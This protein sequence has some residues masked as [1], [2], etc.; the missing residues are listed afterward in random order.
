MVTEKEKIHGFAVYWYEKMHYESLAE[1]DCEIYLWDED[2][3]E[4]GFD[5]VANAGFREKYKDY[6][7]QKQISDEVIESEQDYR[8]L[9][10]LIYYWLRNAQ[11]EVP[12]FDRLDIFSRD[13]FIKML[14]QLGRL[15]GADPAQFTGIPK[16]IKIT[17]HDEG[18][19]VVRMFVTDYITQIDAEGNVQHSNVN[20]SENSCLY[21]TT[22]TEKIIIPQDAARQILERVSEVFRVAV[23]KDEREKYALWEIEIKNT[24]G[25]CYRYASNRYDIS[26]EDRTDIS[27]IIR[28]TIGM[29][30]IYLFDMRSESDYI[31]GIDLEYRSV[32]CTER[33]WEIHET[34]PPDYE[35][36]EK[37]IINRDRGTLEY[38][39]ISHTDHRV[40][41]MHESPK[42]VTNLLNR[43]H[44][45]NLFGKI[46]GDS[47][48]VIDTSDEK[49]FY[50]ITV[51]QT[52]HPPRT[53]QGTFDR[54]NLPTSYD[55]FAQTVASYLHPFISGDIF[56]PEIYRQAKHCTTDL[57]FCSVEFDSGIKSYYYLTEDD[58]IEIG[59]QVLV[60]VGRNNH[61]K[62][63]E[64]VD[65]EYFAKSCAPIP[66]DKVKSIIRKLLPGEEF[67]NA[68]DS[69]GV[70]PKGEG[71][72]DKSV[73]DSEV[74]EMMSE[75]L[76]V[77]FRVKGEGKE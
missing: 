76:Q 37:L 27:N 16:S 65:K 66:I 57:I 68:G 44:P 10:S 41:Q 58:T 6:L 3:K 40:T 69:A 35:Y 56:S 63:V 2:A 61:L 29:S 64:V 62:V 54:N 45:V 13:C 4:L 50:T 18:D 5:I 47:G 39:K 60:P 59:D 77:T 55:Y 17:F 70:S 36:K 52:N 7:R 14:R 53:I 33:S 34:P 1:S 32:L 30:G 26:V 23:E 15:T 71:G 12:G 28:E 19:C 67:P 48:A 43:F 21:F 11:K 24:K 42:R 31:T 49:R 46:T 22:K 73:E 25:L 74:R 75:P 8:E 38:I 72:D 51:E 9:G 20:H